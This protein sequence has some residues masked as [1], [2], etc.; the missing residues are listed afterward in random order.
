L[1]DADAELD[2]AV[3]RKRRIAFSQRR[4]H[5]GRTS[6]RIDDAGE[7][8]PESIAGGLDEAALMAR[9]LRVDHLGNAAP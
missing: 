1:V 5:F 9:G 8:D 6:D 4:L 3:G 7:L 2:A